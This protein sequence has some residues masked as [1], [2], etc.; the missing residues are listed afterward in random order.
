MGKPMTHTNGID[1]IQPENLV[2]HQDPADHPALTNDESCIFTYKLAITAVS[3]I[4]HIM[5]YTLY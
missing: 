4:P 3:V 5:P 2:A 1:Q